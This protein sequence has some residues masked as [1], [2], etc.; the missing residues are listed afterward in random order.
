M[1][2]DLEQLQ[3]YPF[4]RL[5][6]LFTGLE[7]PKSLKNIPLSI[8]EPK[9]PPPEFVAHAIAASMDKISVYPNTKGALEL[10]Q[11]IE[12]WLKD[13][14]KLNCVDPESQVLPVNGTREA[15]FSFAQATI[16]R[17]DNPTIL[18][19]NPFYQ[20]YEGASIL[21]GASIYFL[22]CDKETEYLTDFTSVP[23]KIWRSCQLIY[24]C[25]P[26]NP[27]GAVLSISKMQELIKLAD[28]YD[29]IIA[30][31]ECYSEIYYDEERPPP[32]LLEA[33][34]KMHRYNFKRCVAFHSL[35]KRSNLPGLR[36]G[37][38]A[39]DADILEQ[40]L[41]YR[42]YHGCAMPL[43][44]QIASIAAWSDEKHVQENRRKYRQK[45][46]DFQEI[47][48][49]I[50]PLDIPD[51]GFY[52]WMNISPTQLGNDEIF[53]KNLFLQQNVTVL[54]GRYLGRLSKNKNPGENYVRMALV[55]PVEE[56]R[57]AAKRIKKFITSSRKK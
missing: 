12:V 45:F 7:P 3:Q 17:S 9:H 21:S 25:S 23:E 40:F 57:E 29:F 2:T 8:G 20:I 51:G 18:M 34:F 16:D 22:N 26:G 4:E 42:T 1:N 44:T 28:K 27:S 14:F 36:S 55:A 10:R 15:L 48:G 46:D 50:L 56:C 33:C 19:P 43:T 37:F 39:G 53:C 11:A 30:S 47:L 38:V 31:D 35:S 54:P 6:T 24:I 49:G 32:G 5:A 13:R 52:L 41:R